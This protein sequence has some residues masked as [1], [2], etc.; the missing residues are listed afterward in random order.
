M[1][2]AD[3]LYALL[4]AAIRARD[5]EVGEPLRALLAIVGEQADALAA[6]IAD[7]YENLFVETADEWAVAYLAD[8]VGTVPL[9][10][11]ASSEDDATALEEL[12]DLRG[13]RLL[14]PS[15]AGARADVARSIANRRR[16]G[17]V[18]A[19]DDVARYASGFPVQLVEG[20]ARTAWTQHRRHERRDLATARPS[21]RLDSAL[22]GRPFDRTT[23]FPDVRHPDGAVGWYHHEHVM[24]A[25]YRQRAHGYLRVAA[26]PAGAPWRFRLDP[27]GLDR[28]LFTRAVRAEGV[29]DDLRAATVP[30]P[31]HPALFEW[32][33]R[34][35]EAAP[36][37][38]AGARRPNT[39]LYGR[40]GE[41]E[42]VPAACLGIWLDDTFQSPALDESAAPGPSY[43]PRI[44][45]RRLDPWPA[46]RPEGPVVAVDVRVGRVAIG[47]GIAD[48]ASL[49]ASF[50]H[51]SSGFVGGGDYDRS[52]WLVATTPD[53]VITVGAAG[54]DHS[55]LTDAVT[56]WVGNGARS[57]LIRVQD[58]RR[59]ECP[60]TVQLGGRALVI[61][62]SNGEWPVLAPAGADG[63]VTVTGRGS[64]TLSGL[65][66]DG[67]IAVGDD[68]DR[69][70]CLHTTL[71]PGGPRTAT[72]ASVE[73]AS[74]AVVGTAPRLRII[75]AFSVLATV[76][77]GKPIDELLV[78]DSVVTMRGET[79]AVVM[80]DA[81]LS[82]LRA[83]RSTFLG[84][85]TA[86]TIDAS[87]CVFDG[88]VLAART[89]EGCVRYCFVPPDDAADPANDS[90]TPRRFACQ[91][92]RAVDRIL[93]GRPDV[94]DAADRAALAAREARRVRP[95]FVSRD[96]GD[97]G[98][99]QLDPSCPDEIATGAEDGSE[100]GVYAHVKQAQRLD[101]LRRR[102][103]EYL[104]A[105][106]TAGVTVIT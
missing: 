38:D 81:A 66:V 82:G 44:V 83:E 104:P 2:A 29:P 39:V 53:A 18:F 13:P 41:D 103:G 28:P 20:L 74:I 51:G 57:C 89:Q 95:L 73:K 12:S 30:V 105:G 46:A 60:V 70:R 64:L 15:G 27:A 48:P 97:T 61:E 71:V 65:V 75:A 94:T 68:V 6:D 34:A 22:T 31:L 37:D 11:A 91:P 96:F 99:A 72:G 79:G 33:L 9:Y 14:A 47:D 102:V 21:T 69:L 85:V 36:R 77:V 86:R 87:E 50:F 49:T 4:P 5:S 1:T 55:T 42:S 76:V 52:A 93:R 59:Y 78:L 7:G 56:E 24:L 62:A 16:K 19:L 40:V 90:R 58:S 92:D 35:H 80:T 45:S 26:R 32:D 88:Q 25:V 100:M 106:I 67:R 17:T 101:N 3:R 54:A 8:L 10:D 84:S 23:R 43:A 63:Q 98:F